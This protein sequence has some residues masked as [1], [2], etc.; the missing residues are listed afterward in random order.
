M[1]QIGERLQ[2]VPLLEATTTYYLLIFTKTM[3]I[4]AF[5]CVGMKKNC[6]AV[7][8]AFRYHG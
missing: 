7:I 4:Q 3:P 2:Y 6:F 8:F 5:Q 1:S